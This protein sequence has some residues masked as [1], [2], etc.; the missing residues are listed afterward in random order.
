[1]LLANRRLYP[2]LSPEQRPRSAEEGLEHSGWGHGFYW[3]LSW[4]SRFFRTCW[5]R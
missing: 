3:R 4:Q 5:N 2:F 1:M